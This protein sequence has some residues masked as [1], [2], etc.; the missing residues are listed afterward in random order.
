GER[1]NAQLKYW[2]ILHKVR[3]SPRRIGRLAKAIH[4]LQNYEAATG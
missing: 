4:V 2:R 3:V 1:A